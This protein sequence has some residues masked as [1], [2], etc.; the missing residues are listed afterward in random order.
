MATSSSPKLLRALHKSGK[1]RALATKS[2]MCVQIDTPPQLSQL[3]DSPNE[4][5]A[6]P[7]D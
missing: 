2:E 4:A 5:K 6:V 1:Q 3:V 7:T